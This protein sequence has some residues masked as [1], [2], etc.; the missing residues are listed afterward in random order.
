M[1]PVGCV[2]SLRCELL[3]VWCDQRHPGLCRRGG[4]NPSIPVAKRFHVVG[5]CARAS[6]HADADAFAGVGPQY[7]I[8]LLSWLSGRMRAECRLLRRV[9]SSELKENDH[10]KRH[11]RKAFALCGAGTER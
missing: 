3:I 10:A 4:T 9:P 7:T 11:A 2:T 6:N 8:L 1:S 5:S